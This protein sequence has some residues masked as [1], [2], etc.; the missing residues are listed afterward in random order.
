[1]RYVIS[2]SS[3]PPRFD[4]IGPVLKALRDQKA[5]PEAVELYIPRSY[6]RFPE[7][8]GGLPEVPEGV[9][10]VRVEKDLGP[11]TKV[12][13]AARARRGQDIEIFYVDDDKIYSSTHAQTALALRKRFPRAAIGGGGFS[14]RA[15]LGYDLPD[16]PKPQMVASYTTFMTFDHQWRRFLGVLHGAVTGQPPT[17]ARRRPIQKSGYADIAEGYAGVLVRPDYFQDEAFDIPPVIWAVDD[18]WLSGM[19]ARQG[20]PIWVDRSLY[21]FDPAQG[22]GTIDPLYHAVIEGLNR[23]AANRACIDY[24]RA[25]YGIWGGTVTQVA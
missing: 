6:R 16:G 14:L 21:K 12:L 10:I 8:G 17:K 18:I 2:L 19:L 9:T 1:M 25:T 4:R 23:D 22:I 20:I 15:N 11:A 13:P 5:R 24:M 3:I 7:W